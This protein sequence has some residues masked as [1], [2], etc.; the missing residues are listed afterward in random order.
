MPLKPVDG[1]PDYTMP[2]VP[3]VTELAKPTPDD[4][5]GFPE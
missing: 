4:V 2:P 1:A 3:V 5:S